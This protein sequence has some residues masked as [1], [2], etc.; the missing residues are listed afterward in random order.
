ME[1]AGGVG[2]GEVKRHHF[3]HVVDGGVAASEQHCPNI[4]GCYLTVKRPAEGLASSTYIQ[5][6]DDDQV[7]TVIGVLQ[8]YLIA[9]H[10]LESGVKP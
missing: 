10:E 4:G 3:V 1:D 9:K 5:M 2:G 8:D 6:H 7:R